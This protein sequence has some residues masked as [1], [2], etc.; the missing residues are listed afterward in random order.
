MKSAG[1]EGAV[2][3]CL[4]DKLTGSGIKS[5]AGPAGPKAD[6]KQEP[7]VK[8]TQT[9]A[10][11]RAVV[12]FLSG[13]TPMKREK[14]AVSGGGALDS[15]QRCFAFSCFRPCGTEARSTLYQSRT[16]RPELG[17]WGEKPRE[18]VTVKLP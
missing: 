1:N 12:V 11:T 10:I 2:Q 15:P 13:S 18:R 7:A 4:R 6:A 9:L 17:E 14:P 5:R 8:L 3:G 16:G